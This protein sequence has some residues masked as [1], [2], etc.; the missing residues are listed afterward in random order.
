[1]R[2]LLTLYVQPRHPRRTH[3]TG[4]IIMWWD[5]LLFITIGPLIGLF[6]YFLSDSKNRSEEHLNQLRE[7]SHLVC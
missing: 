2:V 7:D 4:G 6:M 5:F 3:K 1:M